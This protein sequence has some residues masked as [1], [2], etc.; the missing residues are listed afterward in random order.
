MFVNWI[1]LYT[2]GGISEGNL[3]RNFRKTPGEIPPRIFEE[4]SGNVLME[5][6]KEL[7]EQLLEELFKKILQGSIMTGNSEVS[8]GIH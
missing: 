2:T 4:L 1:F 5:L 8:D 6:L 3:G 7:P